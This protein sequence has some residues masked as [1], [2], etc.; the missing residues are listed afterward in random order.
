MAATTYHIDWMTD[1]PRPQRVTSLRMRPADFQERVRATAQDTNNIILG[2]HAKERCEERGITR[3]DVVRVLQSGI[4]KGEIEQ[5]DTLEWKGKM[6]R[7]KGERDVGVIT[8]ILHNGKL[9]VKTVEWEYF[10]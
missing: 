10:K 5:T 7:E 1:E 9:F 2:T 8:I 3:L 4:V 6:V